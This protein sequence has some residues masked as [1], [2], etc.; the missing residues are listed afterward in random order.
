MACMVRTR[1]VVQTRTHAQKYFQKLTKAA[2][3]RE[4]RTF[5][6]LFCCE[7]LVL[8][9]GIISL[10]SHG[11][12]KPQESVTY[13]GWMLVLELRGSLQCVP[14]A[15][16]RLKPALGHACPSSTSDHCGRYSPLFSVVAT[17]ASNSS[18][19]QQRTSVK[20]MVL[21]SALT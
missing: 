10:L 13:T 17:D 18:I 21:S 6:A 11:T 12:E 7:H 3:V 15:C 14:V 19:L 1:T 2:A 9:E 5:V 16:S 4:R 20:M 8:F